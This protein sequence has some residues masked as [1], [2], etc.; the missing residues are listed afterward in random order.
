MAV[1]TTVQA[2]GDNHFSPSSD[3]LFRHQPGAAS[4]PSSPGSRVRGSDGSGSRRR[5]RRSA[6]ARQRSPPQQMQAGEQDSESVQS[7][8]P[9]PPPPPPPPPPP[10]SHPPWPDATLSEQSSEWASGAPHAAGPYDPENPTPM[11]R[12][13]SANLQ[14]QYMA[15]LN[16]ADGGANQ[17]ALVEQYQQTMLAKAMVAVSAGICGAALGAVITAVCM[18]TIRDAC[19]TQ[20]A[21]QPPHPVALTRRP[22]MQCPFLLPLPRARL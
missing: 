5:R 17:V 1:A 4:S 20:S 19:T 10:L 7:I 3:Y 11:W 18:A 9:L 22:P 16:A 12:E 21:V 14:G 8:P 13:G 2:S 6:P 15:P